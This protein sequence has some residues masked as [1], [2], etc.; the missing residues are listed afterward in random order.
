MTNK[1]ETKKDPIPIRGPDE[2]ASTLQ[3]ATLLPEDIPADGKIPGG[4]IETYHPKKGRMMVR[5]GST[6]AKEE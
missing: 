6:A 3:E 2:P 5:G 1:K 4:Y